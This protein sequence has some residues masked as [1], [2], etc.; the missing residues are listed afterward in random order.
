MSS[1]IFSPQ[2]QAFFDWI[3]T[4]E[5]S[6]VLEAVAGSGKTTT[7][8]EGL[9]YMRGS[10]YFGAFNKKICDEIATKARDANVI[11]PDIRI[12]TLHSAGLYA[13]N[14]NPRPV[15]DDKKVRNIIDRLFES[16]EE[17]REMI[18]KTNGFIGKLVGFGKKYML[19]RNSNINEW[20]SLVDHF[21]LEEEIAEDVDLR[22]AISL[23]LRVFQISH[24]QCKQVIDFDDMIYAPLAYGRKFRKY[25][26]V[27]IDEAQ[28]TNP[29]RLMLAQA[30]LKPGGRLV[31]V[32]DRHQAIYG[33]TGASSDSLDQIAKLFS[34]CEMPLTV[35]YR[36]PKKVVAYAQTWVKHIQSAETAIDGLVRGLDVVSR[37]EEKDVPWYQTEQLDKTDAV[38]CRFTRPLIETA[39]NLIRV[40]VGCRVEGRDI[41]LG[42]IVLAK[43]WKVKTLDALEKRLDVYQQKAVAKA[44]E[45]G[46]ETAEQ[47]VIDK[48]E[49]LH[50]LIER[51]RSLG[52]TGVVDLIA[53][54]EALFADNVT[55]VLVLSTGH[56]AKG[57]EWERV[58][59]LQKRSNRRMQDWERQQEDNICYV[60]ATRAKKELVLIDIAGN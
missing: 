15:V 7:L 20:M 35:S 2:Q 44:K 52:K 59:W 16:E 55:G 32:G 37:V 23:A 30:M 26:W 25:D 49:T 6:C 29:A 8:I 3:Q 40:G 34:C 10:V 58:Y 39:Y 24:D 33:F 54:I 43:R 36:C 53:E 47:S 18:R 19:A 31:A 48:V 4:G 5:G 1:M 60:L 46:N 13:W 38:L 28:D 50:V 42:L 27:L 9:R 11:R 45:K 57:R 41:G 22:Q 12:S 56:K 17:D 21:S 51:C 14:L